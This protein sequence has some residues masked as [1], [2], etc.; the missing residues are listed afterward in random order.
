VPYKGSPQY[1]VDLL[2]GRIDLVIAAAGPLLP[3]IKSG[4]L[5]LLAVS[6][7]KRDPAMPGVP[8][9]GEEGVPGFEVLGWYG[10]LA[11]AGTPLPV[12]KKLYT[13]VVRILTEPS[14][15]T[16]YV[17]VGLEAV[18]SSSP[19]EFSAFITSERIKWAKV[20]KAAN[21]RIE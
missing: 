7:A 18:T 17:S 5:L 4:R 14:V 10:L 13:E 3:H 12:I 2:A 20:I 15:K 1:T 9:I 8:T 19:A 16:I 11:P 21:I 6:T